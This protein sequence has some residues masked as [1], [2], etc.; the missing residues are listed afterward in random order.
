M[1]Y[2]DLGCT[3]FICNVLTSHEIIM[4]ASLSTPPIYESYV[5]LGYAV[6]CPEVCW[7]CSQSLADSTAI[8]QARFDW[9][10]RL[11][12]PASELG[13]SSCKLST[14][15]SMEVTNFSWHETSPATAQNI[16]INN[17]AERDVTK[18]TCSYKQKRNYN[19]YNQRYFKS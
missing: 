12:Y 3:T 1:P 11:K 4:T 9:I 2:S 17:I 5:N 10:C 18:R 14:A 15:R 8:V 6:P 13:R 19:Y 7:G 16:V